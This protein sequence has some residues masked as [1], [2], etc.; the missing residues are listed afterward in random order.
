MNKKI[1]KLVEPN[2]KLFLF[3]LVLFAA[4]TYFFDWRLA[5][6]EG[7]VILVLVIYSLVDIRFK[8]KKLVE[9]IESVTYST[10]SAKNDTLLHFPLPMVMFQLQDNRV[11]WGNQAFF[12]ICGRQQP[13]LEANMSDLVSEDFSGKWL[14]EGKTQYPGLLELGGRRYQIHGNIVR[15]QAEEGSR[16]FMGVT[17]WVDVT[18][19]DDIKIEYAN[20]RPV[21]AVILLDNYDELI[22]NVPDRMKLELRGM[23]EDK[24]TQWIEGRGGFLR[25]IDRDRYVY[26]FEQRHLRD[27]V[28]QKFELIQQAHDVVSPSGIH[29][30]VSVGIGVDGASYEENFSFASLSVEMALSRGGDQAVIKNRINFEFYGGRGT[31][32][33][34]RTKV[35]SRVTANAL[36]ELIRASSQVF[37]MGHRFSD[38]DSLGAAVGVSCIA[39]KLGT[40]AKIVIDLEK[41]AVDK[42]IASLRNVDEYKDA[43]I[44][45]NSAMV[46]ADSKTLLVVVDT[47]RP[48]QVED[49]N[50][51]LACT[52]VAVIDHH[53]RTST[54]IQ[55][56]ALTFLEPYASSVCELMTELLQELVEQQDIFVNE[57][58]AMLAGIVMDT[59]N[60]TIRTGERTF[61]A[62]AFLRRAGADTIEVKKLLQN[63]M[64]N[65]VAKYTILRNAKLYRESIAIAA[66][67]TPQDRVVA[68]QAADELLNV[69]GVAASIVLFPTGDGGVNVSARSI[70]DVNVQVLLEK[71]GGGGNKSAA[72][73]Q[74]KDMDLREAFNEICAAIDSYLDD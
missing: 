39:R 46:A 8:Q 23:V 63:D 59:K 68:A 70:G 27:F 42:L 7:G 56:A 50:L 48:E 25:R 31:E 55:N 20:S 69:S 35:K 29:A 2:R 19:F 24:I 53:R 37:I 64:D 52:R 14:M 62:A 15:S 66:P 9:Y 43:F 4:A 11:I 49:E 67:D 30:T 45:P 57:A 36:A 71:L 74:L 6:A 13:S 72:G 22:K 5:A 34:T 1:K 54:F 17:Y 16:N 38:M 28:E 12:E 61:D 58:E 65:T 47:N 18:E 41:N 51:L 10:E 32:I 73:A 3:V 60:F 21:V 33:E 40:K 44:S 26:I